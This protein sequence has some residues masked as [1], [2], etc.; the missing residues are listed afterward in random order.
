MEL[1]QMQYLVAAIESKSLNKA[2]EMLYTSQPNVSKIIKSL[3]T[4]LNSEIL[5]RTSKGISLTVFGEEIYEYAKIMLRN[6]QIIKEVAQNA[7]YKKLKIAT[8][9]SNMV[10]RNLADYYMSRREDQLHIELQEGTAEEVIQLVW[11]KQARIGILYFAR[12]QESTLMR[13]LE[14]KNLEFTPLRN[15]EL[16]LY[17]GKL[18]PYYDKEEI[19][20]EELS[21]L[22]Y[23]QWNKDYFSMVHQLE[24]ISLGSIRIDQLNHLVHTNSDHCMLDMLLYTDLCS[25]GLDF[26]QPRYEQYDIRTVKVSQGNNCLVV[27]FISEGVHRLEPYEREYIQSLEEL[28]AQGKVKEG[29][30]GCGNCDCRTNENENHYNKLL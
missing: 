26:M 16:C 20:F 15:C 6:A 30:C 12:K 14:T 21:Y 9:P 25:I 11:E 17:V 22:K 4:E 2:A 10:A 7:G 24:T 1:K 23:V 29:R 5:I 3:E 8:Y 18:H 27:G 13:I 28:F 19:S